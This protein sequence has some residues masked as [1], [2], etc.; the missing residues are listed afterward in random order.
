MVRTLTLSVC[1]PLLF[2]F[3]SYDAVMGPSSTP[4][5]ISAFKPPPPPSMSNIGPESAVESDV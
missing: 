1:K 3:V 5:K 4:M 2:V